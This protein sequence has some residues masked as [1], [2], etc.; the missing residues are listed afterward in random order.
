MS[1]ESSNVINFYKRNAAN[2]DRERSRI[3][4]EKAW[5]D[6]FQSYIP[7]GGSV[8]DVGCGSGQPIAAYLI[9]LGYRLTGLDSSPQLIALCESRF[10]D[11]EWCTADMR[12]FQSGKLFD[13]LLAWDS[14][15]HL[16]HADQK[17]MFPIF[18]ACVKP[19]APLMFTA[20][21]EYSEAINPLWGM[22]LYHA[23]F[24]HDEYAEF[25][26]LNGFELVDYKL[27]D[28]D[29]GGRSVFLAQHSN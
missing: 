10:P 19:G 17:A 25:L 28:P 4:F 9:S 21:P 29:C 16:N 14:F 5:L 1:D 6:K 2:F 13:G 8:L 27:E 23:S 11:H 12:T 20:G 18:R 7:A 3:L 22:P 15:F 24:A 26:S